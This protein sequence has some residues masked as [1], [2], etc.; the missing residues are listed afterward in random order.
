M[1]LITIITVIIVIVIIVIITM[2]MVIIV[3]TTLQNV[4]DWEGLILRSRRTVVLCKC[5][6]VLKKNIIIT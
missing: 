6:V 1:I 2:I 4:E 5:A 3:Y